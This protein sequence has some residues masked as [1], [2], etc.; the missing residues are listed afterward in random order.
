MILLFM[1][2]NY[3]LTYIV[4]DKFTKI[5]KANLKEGQDAIC[6]N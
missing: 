4:L 6:N 5:E 3:N 1:V 2:K